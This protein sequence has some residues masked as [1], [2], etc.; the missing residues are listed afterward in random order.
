MTTGPGVPVS[1]DG[2]SGG[3]RRPE[4]IT[5][6]HLNKL[7]LVYPRQSTP[8]QVRENT[9]ST[10]E[11]RELA[12]LARQWGWPEDRIVILDADLGKSGRS[13]TNRTDFQK[14]VGLIYAWEVGAVFARDLQRLGRDAANLL[15]FRKLLACRRSR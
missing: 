13:T 10:A 4:L 6:W 15:D 14:M 1:A 3:P 2:A 7:A 9:G 12:D 5:P 11:Q 8:E